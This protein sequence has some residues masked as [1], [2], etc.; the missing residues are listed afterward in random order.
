MGKKLL[1]A[2]GAIVVAAGGVGGALT[3]SRVRRD[4]RFY[5]EFVTKLHLVG[6]EFCARRSAAAHK[7]VTPQV[8]VDLVFQPEE[9]DVVQGGLRVETEVVP[10][11]RDLARL[12][13]TVDGTEHTLFILRQRLLGGGDTRVTVED[14]SP[15]TSSYITFTLLVP[16]G[17]DADTVQ[18]KLASIE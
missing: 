8:A 14:V 3:A 16:S 10:D 9:F 6:V 4:A 17:E 2:V 11:D 12:K 1:G 5:R 7:D 15:I 18:Q 13:V